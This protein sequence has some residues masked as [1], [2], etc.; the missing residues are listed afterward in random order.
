VLA[1]SRLTGE[2]IDINGGFKNGGISIQVVSV[3]GERVRLG[4]DAPKSVVIYRR[5]VQVEIDKKSEKAAE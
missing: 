2:A 4:I 5:E 3:R 1:L